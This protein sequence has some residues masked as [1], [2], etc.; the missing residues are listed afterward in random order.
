MRANLP[1]VVD[2]G[3]VVFMRSPGKESPAPATGVAAAVPGQVQ[4]GF[5]LLEIMLVVVLIGITVTF[6][7]LRLDPDPGE[8]AMREA[9]RVAALIRQLREESILRA[10]PMAFVFDEF[11]QRYSFALLDGGEWKPVVAADLFRPRRIQ[12]PVKASLSID[13]GNDAAAERPDEGKEEGRVMVVVDPVGE[14]TPFLMALTADRVI[15][16]VTLD[17][18]AEIVVGQG[19]A[20]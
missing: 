19:K 16:N 13:S 10:R 18:Y 11:E 14:T 8:V 6:V 17:A 12:S 1:V 7:N 20:E 3:A 2:V 5:T 4:R 15:V 9:E